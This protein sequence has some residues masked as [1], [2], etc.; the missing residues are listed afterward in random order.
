MAA[1]SIA[2]TPL[3]PRARRSNT[4]AAELRN[5]ITTGKLKP[6]DQ[7]PT[8][9]NLCQQF[10]VSRTT[11]REAIQMLR[12]HGL[13][14]VTPGRGSFVRTPDCQQLMADLAMA[15]AAL[16]CKSTCIAHIRSLLQRDIASQL[17]KAPLAQRQ[18]LYQ[19]VL[20]RLSTPE[21][22]ARAEESWHIAMAALTGSKLQIL[23][24][25]TLL[26]L[27]TNRRIEHYRNPDEVMRTIHIQMRTNAAL[28]EGDF[29]LAERVLGQYLSTPLVADAA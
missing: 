11:L 5:L 3:T 2:L 23:L 27:E 13:L 25:Q 10:G 18:E 29:A 4:I 15:A 21:E 22:N 28:C 7:L 20:N 9:S 14:E 19:H 16:G 26:A 17:G 24:M 6:G 1:A 12:T 8:E